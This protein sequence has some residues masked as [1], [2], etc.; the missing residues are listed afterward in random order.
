MES[1]SSSRAPDP[2]V[3]VSEIGAGLSHIQATRASDGTFALVYIPDGRDVTVSLARL[4][5]PRVKA[6]WYSPRDG[7]SSAIGQFESAGTQAFDP[8]GAPATGN[9]WVLALES[10]TLDPAIRPDTLNPR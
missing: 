4:S 5:G 9:D 10:V 8:P 7:G 3:V 2:S 6:S 1:H